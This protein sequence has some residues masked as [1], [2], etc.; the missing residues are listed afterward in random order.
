MLR[1]KTRTS[2]LLG[3]VTAA[4]VLFCAPAHSGPRFSVETGRSCTYCHVQPDGGSA[5]T[6]EGHTFRGNGFA[7]VEGEA[8]PVWKDFALFAVG[9]VHVLFAFIWFGAIFYV[10]IMIGPKS[11]VA[12]LPS[13]EMKLG[14]ISI[15]VVLATGVV[16]TWWR[17][18]TLD[19]LW[20]TTWGIVW[21]V[22]VALFVGMVA[23]AAYVTTRLNRKLKKEAAARGP[24]PTD[25]TRGQ[26]V[27]VVFG[28]NIYDVTESRMW[29]GGSHMKRHQ[30]GTDLTAAMEGAPHGAEVLERFPN[31]G[32]AEPD[33]GRKGSTAAGA[34]MV[35][36][37]TALF[38]A[39]GILLCVAYWNYG[40]PLA[41][42]AVESDVLAREEACI[43]CHRETTAGIFED[44]RHSAHARSNVS[45]MDCHESEPGAVD[46]TPEHAKYYAAGNG[47]DPDMFTAIATVV[48]P[49]DCAG[50]HPVQTRQYAKSKH[51][52]TLE[53]IWEIDPWLKHGMN[54][55]LERQSG[56]WHCHGSVLEEKDGEIDPETWPNVGVGRVNL[57]GSRG[58]C[59]SCHTRHRFSLAE[60][61][62]PEACG[63]CHLGP[64][65][66]QIEIYTESKHGDI[67]N[68]RRDDFHWD[69]PAGMWMA[70]RDYT[71]PTCATCHMS[72][73]RDVP[74]SHDVT[75]R[76]AW[77]LQAPLTIRPEDFAPAPAETD[78]ETSR[79]NMRSV[80]TQCHGDRWTD[81]HFTMMDG[82]VAEYNEAYYKPA[83]KIM[84][85]LAAEGLVDESRYFDEPIEVEFYELWHHEGRRARMG[86]AMMAP[87]YS[88]WHGFYEAKLRFN[89]LERMARELRE[90][91]RPVR[92]KDFPAATGSTQPPRSLLPDSD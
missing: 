11:L 24:E 49:K 73:T 31:L 71:A 74:G 63:Q 33:E 54:S 9:F 23:V 84:D 8:P 12:G 7:F 78:W 46:S 13:S 29:R 87:D 21:C 62:K 82:V 45:C 16:L 75:P 5:L 76:L 36:A 89:E 1:S 26:P 17:L 35:L 92:A 51:A 19:T 55:S 34:F 18:P 4:L 27:H 64:D 10:H 43:D 39:F 37:Y 90:T 32:P 28:G 41:A 72:A 47:G 56:C 38:S 88:W 91:G 14:R 70:G 81:G 61:R 25:G 50:C 86:A 59:T 83:R 79:E 6:P 15:L 52:N 30:A 60:A 44:W 69:A 68:A 48:T 57:D 66:P 40:P 85:A 77:E 22:K 42:L 2:L 80:C 67:V 20:G 53:I 58:S 3:V 65:H